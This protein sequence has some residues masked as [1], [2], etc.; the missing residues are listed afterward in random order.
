ML[1]FFTVDLLS[2]FSIPVKVERINGFKH[3]QFISGVTSLTYWLN[4]VTFDSSFF[5]LIVLLR[6]L[7]FKQFDDYD[8]FTYSPHM[9]QYE[10]IGY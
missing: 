9:R 4:T 5:L 2:Y 7:L 8:F 6:I 3:I 10:Y 1:G